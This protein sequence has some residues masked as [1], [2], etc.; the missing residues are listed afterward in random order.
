MKIKK[1]LSIVAICGV[2]I[3][4]FC[5]E[6]IVTDKYEGLG[7]L[8]ENRAHFIR[9]GKIGFLDENGVEVIKNIY[10]AVGEFTKGY[11]IV[12]SD[13]SEKYIVIDKFGT[14]VLM[15]YDYVKI[16]GD[17]IFFLKKGEKNIL[18]VGEK[19]FEVGDIVL[20]LGEGF[21]LLSEG[22]RHKVFSAKEKRV[23]KEIEGEYLG[24]SKDNILI[25]NRSGVLVYNFIDE[26]E[27]VLNYESVDMYGD[28]YIIGKQK[29]KVHI[30]SKDGKSIS[31]GVDFI[32]PKVFDKF[33]VG[34]ESGYGVLNEKGQEI[35]ESK[36]DGIQLTPNYIVV[37]MEEKKG[38]F[39][40]EGK[41]VLD[42]KY[43]D[44]QYVD[45]KIY[46]L[47]ENGWRHV[48]LD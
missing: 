4:F 22:N 33:I 32:Y 11:A 2:A 13:N 39:N 5:R 29:G 48:L 20:D 31:K 19:S 23:K 41:K 30:Y 1:I 44:I 21:Y 47:D 3:Y 40:G 36:Y 46:V 43:I 18:K 34:E 26:S 9:D 6:K 38:I 17:G 12:L 45:K 16:Y 7:N 25:K 42:I 28:E 37:E 35:L 24:L 10:S 8:K 14:E 15:G 27:Q